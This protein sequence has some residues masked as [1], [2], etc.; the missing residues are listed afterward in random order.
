MVSGVP[1]GSVLGLLLFI[2][3]TADMWN[4]LENKV[5][6]Y[7]DDATL[8]SEV[9]SPFDRINVANFLNRDLVKIQS[10]YSTRRI[11][12]NYFKTHS[13]TISQSRT[14]QNTSS[15]YFVWT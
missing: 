2:L 14:A 3:Y 7:T 9:A 10:W 1:Q 4:D 12:L 11:K 13:I 6:L 15:S 8:Y 5:I